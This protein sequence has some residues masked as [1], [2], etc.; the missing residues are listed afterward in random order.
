MYK[1]IFL[2]LAFGVFSCKEAS[3]PDSIKDNSETVSEGDQM[4]GLVSKTNI[5]DSP[6]PMQLVTVADVESALG[7]NSGA[8]YT[9]IPNGNATER[10]RSVFYKIS[11]EDKPNAA[12]LFHLSGNPL[13]G[14]LEDYA[15]I[16]VRDKISNGDRSLNDPDKII[17]FEAWDV[18]LGGASNKGES[19]YFWTDERG[20]LF[21][22]AFN[23]SSLSE[24]EQYQAA[25][26]LANKVSPKS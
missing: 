18:G 2:F 15:L 7:L 1:F 9:T 10:V 13:P 25:T 12:M 17:E 20:Y 19:T 11:E 22:I 6:D 14:E 16:A 26:K 5:Y 24:E 23:L 3:K 4:S 21:L 8:V